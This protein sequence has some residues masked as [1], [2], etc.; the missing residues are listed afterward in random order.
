MP[1]G[2]GRNLRSAKELGRADPKGGGSLGPSRL[3]PRGQTLGAVAVPLAAA[4][5]GLIPASGPAVLGA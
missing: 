5:P 4:L 3:L 1:W 2:F